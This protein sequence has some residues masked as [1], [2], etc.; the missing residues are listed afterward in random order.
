MIC[1]KDVV[2]VVAN[3]TFLT[4]YQR[5]LDAEIRCVPVEDDNGMIC[6]ILRY[7][8][9]LRLLLRRYVAPL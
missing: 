8:D 5:M 1:H 2:K 7:I 4:A 6:G 3:D 9:L